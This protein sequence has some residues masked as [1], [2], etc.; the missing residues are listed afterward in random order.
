MSTDDFEFTCG[1]LGRHCFALCSPPALAISL[2]EELPESEPYSYS[3]G[4]CPEDYSCVPIIIPIDILVQLAARV[5]ISAFITAPTLDPVAI[6]ADPLGWLA[7]LD[8]TIFLPGSVSTVG[9]YID[10]IISIDG[11]FDLENLNADFMLDLDDD[12]QEDLLFLEGLLNQF[13]NG[14]AIIPVP[15]PIGL[16]VCT[17]NEIRCRTEAGLLIADNAL[18][19]FASACPPLGTGEI[20]LSPFCS[21]PCTTYTNSCQGFQCPEGY[22]ND[23]FGDFGICV[24][25]EKPAFDLAG[26]A[27]YPVCL[28]LEAEVDA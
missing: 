22:S 19:P 3:Q 12:A 17:F 11:Q 18:C 7:S 4:L 14:N 15:L 21:P 6:F 28:C 27:S 8:L 25:G 1:P 13:I 24:E 2:N 23:Q 20:A 5:I 26:L 9:Q 16:G 10:F